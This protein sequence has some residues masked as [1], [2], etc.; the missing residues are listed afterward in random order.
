MRKFLVLIAIWVATGW[1]QAAPPSTESIE[2]LLTITKSER[3]MDSAYANLEPVM[4]QSMAQALKDKHLNAAQQK[5]I[6]SA[7]ARF[8]AVFREEMTFA[9]LKPLMVQMYQES[10]SQEEIDGLASFYKS[11][12]GVAM[13]EKMPIVMQKTMTMMQ[14]MMPPMLERFGAVMEALLNEVKAAQ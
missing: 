6:D 7:P 8:A 14:T 12:A 3:L 1:A 11:P 9:K 10:F 4:R 13:I 5:I 2:A